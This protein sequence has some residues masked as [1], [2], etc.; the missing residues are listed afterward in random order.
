LDKA[1]ETNMTIEAV[2]GPE[3]FA[4]D[5][6]S[7]T[8]QIGGGCPYCGQSDGYANDV[9]GG[10]R[11]VDNYGI[12]KAHGVKWLFGGNLLSAGD[13]EAEWQRHRELLDRLRKVEAIH[14]PAIAVE[15]ALARE[16]LERAMAGEDDECPF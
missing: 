8:D 12:C 11:S 9:Y 3:P 7:I 4:G 6:M 10:G 2:A 1:E 13:D 14:P 15:R 16:A 5:P